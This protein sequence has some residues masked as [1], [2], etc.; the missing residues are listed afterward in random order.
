MVVFCVWRSATAMI[1]PQG[2]HLSVPFLCKSYTHTRQQK[3]KEKFRWTDLILLYLP[4]ASVS[5]ISTV[6]MLMAVAELILRGKRL[7]NIQHECC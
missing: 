4:F 2:S 5:N 6:V 3:L 1:W 7:A